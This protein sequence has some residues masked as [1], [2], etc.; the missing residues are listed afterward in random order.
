MLLLLL[1]LLVLCALEFDGECFLWDAGVLSEV[2]SRVVLTT[3]GCVTVFP[4]SFDV[5]L[6]LS[7]EFFL[8]EPSTDPPKEC[9]DAVTGTVLGLISFECPFPLPT[10]SSTE[11]DLLLGLLSVTLLSLP[12]Q[13][14]VLLLMVVLLVVSSAEPSLPFKSYLSSP[15]GEPPGP[16]TSFCVGY[17]DLCSVFKFLIASSSDFVVVPLLPYS[18]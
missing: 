16:M 7:I 12:L 10:V 17:L 4:V 13:T 3:K 6:T 5:I 1:L 18:Y 2:L 15:R 14:I 9:S 11:A 8:E